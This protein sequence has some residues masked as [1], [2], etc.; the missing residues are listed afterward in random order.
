MNIRQPVLLCQP[1][2]FL[3][4]HGMY[5]STIIEFF[6]TIINPS[7]L[8]RNCNI[9]KQDSPAMCTNPDHLT[10]YVVSG[11]EVVEYIL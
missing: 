7:F 1:D 5:R 10:E 2:K 8:L 4:S 6:S 11:T 3:R 9:S